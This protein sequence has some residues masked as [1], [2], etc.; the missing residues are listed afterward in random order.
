MKVVVTGGGGFVGS[1]VVE[2]YARQGADVLALDNFSRWRTL[3]GHILGPGVERF[4]W[5]YIASLPRVQRKEADV[6][7]AK[8]ME[9][10]LRDANAIVHT[11]GQ[12]AATTSVQDPRTDFEINVG[13]TFNI[14]E[15]ARKAD[16]DP[17][18]IFCSTNKVY[19]GNVNRIPVRAQATRYVYSDPTFANGIPENFETDQCQHTPYGASKFAADLYV[20]EYARTYG[21]RAGVFR[22]SCV[23]GTRQ[24]GMED[25][26]W[27]AHFVISSFLGKPI[28]IYGD[29][30][31]VRDILFVEDLMRAYEAFVA[32]ASQLK[33]VV[34]NIGGGPGFTSSLLELVSL[35][36][37]NL[38]RKLNVSFANRRP[39]DQKVY[40]SDIRR[41]QEQL[42]W[43]PSVGPQEGVGR[44][45][46]WLSTRP[47][48]RI[49][50]VARGLQSAPRLT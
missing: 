42:Y 21:L 50:T 6:R 8:A 47:L 44:I 40:V 33:G 20:Q 27:V 19:G 29:G 39:A 23:Y 17:V 10:A 7:D 15:A 3:G 11:A 26:G 13:G 32:R 49:R 1:H 45:L 24:F 5:D 48:T 25:Q 46:E 12:V 35:I 22:M 16:S 9:T 4:N 30:K 43:K 18:V 14:L 41:A 38:G 36:E 2:R 28:T 37:D 31:Q 34:P